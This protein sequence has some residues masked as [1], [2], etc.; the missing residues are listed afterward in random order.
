MWKFQSFPCSIH[1]EIEKKIGI[2]TMW[3][4]EWTE[5]DNAIIMFP[6][7]LDISTSMYIWK[8]MH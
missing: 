3:K 6:N 1:G 7:L 5:M 4:G 8:D 2:W